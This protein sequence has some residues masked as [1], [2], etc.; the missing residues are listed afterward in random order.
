[1]VLQSLYSLPTYTSKE[2][3][4][5]HVNPHYLLI[6]LKITVERSF[7]GVSR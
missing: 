4:W 2:D 1:M 3:T 5:F 7:L 6:G